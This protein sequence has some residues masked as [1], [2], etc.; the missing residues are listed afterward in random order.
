MIAIPRDETLFVYMG[1]DQVFYVP[2]YLEE[3]LIYSREFLFQR[4]YLVVVVCAF[5]TL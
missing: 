2:E 5:S 4:L 3:L 1:T